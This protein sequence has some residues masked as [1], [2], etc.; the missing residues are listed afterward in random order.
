M[1]MYQKEKYRETQIER[2]T[3]YDVSSGFSYPCK[4]STR[5]NNKNIFLFYKMTEELVKNLF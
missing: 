4:Y 3:N 2:Q 5:R 1:E